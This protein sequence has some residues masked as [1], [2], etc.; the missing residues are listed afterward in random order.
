MSMY[1]GS[2]Y[3]GSSASAEFVSQIEQ[4]ILRSNV[5]IEVSETEEIS[6]IGQRGIWLNKAEVNSWRGDMNISEYRIH[7]D[8]K[9]QVI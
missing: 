6:A 3:G 8:S 2:S 4:A 1:G 9:Q 5:P 7:Q